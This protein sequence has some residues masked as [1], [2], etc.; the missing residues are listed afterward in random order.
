MNKKGML[1]DLFDYLFTVMVVFLML[2]IIGF[3]FEF[4]DHKRQETA[5]DNIEA[6]FST[7][8]D[9]M[10]Q[11]RFNIDQDPQTLIFPLFVLIG[12]VYSPNDKILLESKFN[13]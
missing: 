4:N 13:D 10:V 9:L 7:D 11:S 3:I 12:E 2:A 1:D 6:T 8:R 5:L